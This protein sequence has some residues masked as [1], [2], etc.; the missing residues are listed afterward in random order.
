VFLGEQFQNEPGRP[1]H[2]FA[3]YFGSATSAVTGAATIA[4]FLRFARG[5]FGGVPSAGSTTMML[6]TNFFA[7]WRSKSIDVRS[8]SDS[9]TTPKP[10]WKCLI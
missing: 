7:P 5:R 2:A 10:Y 3:G 4:F 8:A 1:R 6:V 9:V